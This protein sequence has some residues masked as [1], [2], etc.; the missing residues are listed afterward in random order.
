MRKLLSC[1]VVLLASTAPV[2]AEALLTKQDKSFVVNMVGGA[3]MT[4]ECGAKAVPGGMHRFADKIGVDGDR[5][6]AAVD[7]AAHAQV[8]EPYERENLISAVTRLMLDTHIAITEGLQ[9]DKAKTCGSFLKTLRE[10]G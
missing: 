2:K 1:V 8:N 5:L 9:R 10:N 7:A 6:I 4:S 3:I